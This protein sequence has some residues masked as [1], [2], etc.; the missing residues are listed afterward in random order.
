MDRFLRH[1]GGR[2]HIV[3]GEPLTVAQI[4]RELGLPDDRNDARVALVVTEYVMRRVA[5]LADKDYSPRRIRA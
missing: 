2:S 3:I 4:K 1:K 5:E